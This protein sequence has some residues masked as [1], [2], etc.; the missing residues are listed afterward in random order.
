MATTTYDSSPLGALFRDMKFQLSM[1]FIDSRVVYTPRGCN[2][3]AHELAALGVSV[4]PED[5]VL[6][7]MN[8]PSSVTRLVTSDLA[9]S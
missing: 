3:P 7:M 1:C 8:Y 4:P 9:V 5:H 6:W 2:K